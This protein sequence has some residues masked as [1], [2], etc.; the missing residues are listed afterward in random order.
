MLLDIHNLF[1]LIKQIYLTFGEDIVK[2]TRVLYDVT[3]KSCKN[4]ESGTVENNTGSE[5]LLKWYYKTDWLKKWKLDEYVTL[6][7]SSSDTYEP[8]DRYKIKLTVSS[9]SLNYSVKWSY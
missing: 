8:D 5:I 4:P 1:F 2:G 3:F 6:S 7:G 9:N